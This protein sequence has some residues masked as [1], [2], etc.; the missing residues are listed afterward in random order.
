MSSKKKHNKA[1]KAS[2]GTKANPGDP[3]VAEEREAT[4]SLRNIQTQL[5]GET[6]F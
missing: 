3:K 1:A 5:F 4:H 6:C 2:L